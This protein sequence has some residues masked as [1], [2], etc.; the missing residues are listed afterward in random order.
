[1]VEANMI[2]ITANISPMQVMVDQ[3]Q[4][5]N[6]QYFSSLGSLIKNDARYT[7]GIKRGI[8]TAKAA[9]NMNKT[10]LIS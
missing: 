9:F 5:E 8:V 6:V 2:R 3:K 4:L 10:F 1:M 7:R